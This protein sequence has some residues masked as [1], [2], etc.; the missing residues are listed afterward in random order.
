ATHQSLP[1]SEILVSEN[2]GPF[3]QYTGPISVGNFNRPAGYWRF[4]I[5]AATGRAESIVIK[6]TAVTSMP[7]EEGITSL[8]FTQLTN[9]AYT[10]GSRLYEAILPSTAAYGF[11]ANNFLPINGS[12]AI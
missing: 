5:K 9:I 11:K 8:M 6:S 12:G 4:K 10:S 3:V 2:N 1:I 7:Y